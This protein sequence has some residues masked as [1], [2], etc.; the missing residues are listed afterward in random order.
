M[1]TSYSKETWRDFNTNDRLGPIHMLN[2]IRL[3]KR[4]IYADGRVATDRVA[5]E[6][7]AR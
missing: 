5:Y 7:T 3:R 4:A 2:L 6:A 1:H